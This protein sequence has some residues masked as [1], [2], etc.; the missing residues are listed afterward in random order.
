MDRFN[1]GEASP[2]IPHLSFA[3]EGHPGAVHCVPRHDVEDVTVLL[4]GTLEGLR[5]GKGSLVGSGR[6]TIEGGSYS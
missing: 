4:S 3:A 5:R 6:Y 1:S 2:P